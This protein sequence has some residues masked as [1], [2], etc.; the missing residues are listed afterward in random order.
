M[1]TELFLLLLFILLV[2]LSFFI[3]ILLIRLIKVS[4]SIDTMVS[5]FDDTVKNWNSV[6]E[7]FDD[8]VSHIRKITE[9]VG[10]IGNEIT[11]VWN[12]I[13]ETE[14]YV[15]NVRGQFHAITFALKT[16]FDTLV[17]ELFRKKETATDTEE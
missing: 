8:S 7:A 2:V 13:R 6:I 9:P 17:S 16:T 3:I 12:T 1:T 10:E 11:K 5:D 15:S 4:R 14:A